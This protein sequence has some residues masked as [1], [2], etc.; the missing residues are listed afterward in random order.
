MSDLHY[1]ITDAIVAGTDAHPVSNKIVVVDIDE[2]T[3]AAHGHWPWPRTT[4]A[5]LLDKITRMGARCIALDFIL[6]EPDPL[7][8][9]DDVL[10]ETLS[11]APVILGYEFL[12]NDPQT[13]KDRCRLHAL[14][15]VQVHQ[16]GFNHAISG[17]YP[18]K[19]VICNLPQFTDA[20]AFSG[21]LNG[22]PDSDGLLRRL[23]III[24]YG[25]SIY[26]NLVLAALL[27]TARD[28]TVTIGQKKDA[29]LYL[30]IDSAAIPIDRNGNVRIR[31][32]AKADHLHHVSADLILKEAASPADFKDRIVFVGLYASGLKAAYQTP[33]R[34][35][36]PAVEIQAQ[37]A[38]TIISKQ[39]IR[40]SP[41]IIYAEIFFSIVLA[42]IYSMFIAKLK[43]IP[44][45]L[46][47]IMGIGGLWKAGGLLF[48]GWQILFSPL[49]PI[50]IL[51]VNGPF[52]MLFKYWTRQK[53]AHEKMHDALI[54]AKDSEKKLNSIIKAIPDI[55]F[56]LD[57]EGRITFISPAVDRYRKHYKDLIGISILDLI[58]PEDRAAAVNRIKERR[59]GKLTASDFEVRIQ[60]AAIKGKQTKETRYF[61]VTTQSIYRTDNPETGLFLGTQGIARDITQRKRLENR[62][63]QSKKM[64]A[65]GNLAAGVAHDLNNILSVLVSYPELLL[66]DLPADSSL[67]KPIETIQASGLRA[68]AIVQDMLTIARLGV[69]T[70]AIVNLNKT[71]ST[72]IDTPEFKKIFEQHPNIQLKTDLADD[73]MNTKGSAIHLSKIILNLTA[74]AAEAMPAGGSISI[75]TRNRYLDKSKEAYETIPEGEYVYLSI[76]DEGIGISTDDLARI[77]EPFYS[78]KEMGRSGSG[79]GMTV[80]WSAVKDHSGYV[81]IQSREGEGTRFDIYL[82]ATRDDLEETDNRV[83]LQDYLGTECIM[84]VDDVPEQREIAVQMLSKLGYNV[85]SANSGE[86]AIVYLETH[87]ADLLVLDMVM[88]PGIDGLETFQR[89]RRINPKQ[90]A[91]IASGYAESR[92][93]NQLQEMGAGAYIQKP[94]TLEK[95][96]LA[97]RNE[98]DRRLDSQ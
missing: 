33:A 14:D 96:G 12:F 71:I 74:N 41:G 73:L 37:L 57:T 79:L 16:P 45:A 92:R 94:Y 77:F 69:K 4:L 53:T 60:M 21:F 36:L 39:F 44:T 86:E 90:K 25:T 89:I 87:S 23:P 49:L 82:P 29:T 42:V 28:P 43:F 19:D 55:V 15:V 81:N 6:A 10:A 52:V 48:H 5:T 59:T 2:N 93:V 66:L 68:A 40:R 98:L 11:R 18:A 61:S 65:V 32:P 3:M 70:R 51:V 20:T 80:V 91:I 62:L 9:N 46:I 13:S 72:Y 75:V 83:V 38:E 88:T 35:L 54:R 1:K 56:R 64:E 47:G 17:L 95:I 31:F 78:K 34:G 58:H 50:A 26:P 30:V 63:E 85:V 76:R 24:R 84:V 22:K 8:A 67:R 7:S 97:V 27:S